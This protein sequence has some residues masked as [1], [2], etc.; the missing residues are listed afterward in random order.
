MIAYLPDV[1]FNDTN[2]RAKVEKI[3]ESVEETCLRIPGVK[4]IEDARKE[5]RE[6]GEPKVADAIIV[7]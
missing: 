6:L 2:N 4:S 7:G 5:I 1:L 3:L